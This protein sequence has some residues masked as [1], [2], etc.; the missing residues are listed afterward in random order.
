VKLRWAAVTDVGMV[1]SNNQDQVLADEPLFAVAD[2]MGGHAAGEVASE[3]AIETLRATF[4]ADPT[5]EGLV[6]AFRQADAAVW[7]RSEE[8]PDTRGMGTTLTAVALIDSDG[9]PVLEVGNVGDSRAYLLRDG[10]LHRLTIDHSLV[11]ELLQAG[12]LTPEEAMN[13]PQRHIVT[14]SIGVEYHG[15]ESVGL[16]VDTFTV[17]PFR[18]DRI[19]LA[20]DGLSDMIADDQIA[21][22]LRRFADPD[23]AA[24]ELI[25]LAKAAG[26][27]DNIS[28]VLVD[29]VDDDD[30]A[31]AASRAL[32]GEPAPPSRAVDAAA[33]ER[34]PTRPTPAASARPPRPPH[35]RRPRPRLTIRTVAFVAAVIGVIGL[36]AIATT[37]YARGSYYVGLRG[38]NVTIFQGRPGGF[39]W[40]KPTVVQ[41]FSLRLDQVPEARRTHLREGQPEPTLGAARHYV[42]N[43]QDEAATLVSTTTTSTT[44]TAVPP[45]QLLQ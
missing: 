22:A 19:L 2:G 4:A 18:G 9:E 21:S 16:E 38:D 5:A 28:V 35:V 44:T 15:D 39:L 31:G 26:G 41:R 37:W 34:Q 29:V 36:A 20:S 25:R 24:R 6:K 45:N 8:Q 27:N 7:Q 17:L 1:R 10:E 12:R 3:V 30:K 40:V 23:D 11:E 33:D 42:T 14:R 43:L 13:H 32:E